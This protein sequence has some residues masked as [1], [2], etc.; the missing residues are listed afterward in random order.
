MAITD[1]SQA[2]ALAEFQNFV[3]K[4]DA[5]PTKTEIGA[6]LS[7]I[8]PVFSKTRKPYRVKV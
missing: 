1:G 3:V 7:L 2:T 4:C 8:D 6:T 5:H